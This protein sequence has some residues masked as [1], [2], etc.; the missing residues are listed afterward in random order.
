MSRKEEKKA[1]GF[2]IAEKFFGIVILLIGALTLH[3]TN[4]SLGDIAQKI[5]EIIPF[6]QV[7]MYIISAGLIAL[8]TFLIF[9]KTS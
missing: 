4:T 1:S 6:V 9:V 3:Y 5:P 7:F 2:A 8:G